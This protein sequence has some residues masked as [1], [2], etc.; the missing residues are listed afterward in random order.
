MCPR[1]PKIVSLTKIQPYLKLVVLYTIGFEIST[2]ILKGIMD[3]F[4]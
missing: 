1:P 3:R 4:K 2:K